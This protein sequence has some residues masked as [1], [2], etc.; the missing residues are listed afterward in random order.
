MV[1]HM[2]TKTKFTK[3]SWMEFWDIC[4]TES[5]EESLI[6]LLIN[7]EMYEYELVNKSEIQT[8]YVADTASCALMYA[9]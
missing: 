9:S 7:R 5:Y 8:W 3:K 2:D 6:K 4:P 1:S